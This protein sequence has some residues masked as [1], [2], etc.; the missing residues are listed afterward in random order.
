M[1][2]SGRTCC[3]LPGCSCGRASRVGLGGK[4]AARLQELDRSVLL[5]REGLQCLEE[6]EAAV[7]DFCHSSS[8][9]PAATRPPWK[10]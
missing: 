1:G 7:D 5:L 6:V 2:F 3:G 8:S 9:S 4:L 10:P